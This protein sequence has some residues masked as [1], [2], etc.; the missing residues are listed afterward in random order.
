MHQDTRTDYDMN[1]KV[2]VVTGGAGG[3]GSV[4]CSTLAEKGAAVAVV[5][6][7][8]DRALRVANGLPSSGKSALALG[9]DVTSLKSVK[10]TVDTIV[11]KYGRIDVLVHCAGNNVKA[12]IL[13]MSL[14]QWQSSL[15]TH[16]TGA[17]LFCQAAGKQMVQQ[18]HGGTVVLMSSVA[19]MAP[20][21]DRGAYTP[22][23]AGL[24]GLAKLLSIEWAR[25]NI[26]VNAVCPGVAMTPMTEMVYRRDPELRKQRLKRMPMGR[27][28]TPRDIG[29]A[30]AFL[31]SD[32]AS[33]ITGQALNVN[34]GAVMN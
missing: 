5:D 32:D 14:K 29:K 8:K 2:A 16:L 23:K 20:V 24:I 7:D 25:Y 12:P 6:L 19:A 4:V 33:E 3:I 11:A 9:V 1:D 28:Q 30:V 13:E 31:A 34:G 18:G 22:A 26:R 10:N 15:D 17:F 27:E 21:P